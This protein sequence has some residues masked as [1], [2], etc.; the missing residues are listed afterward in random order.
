MPRPC[1]IYHHSLG[2]L[3]D[4]MRRQQVKMERLPGRLQAYEST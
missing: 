4:G 2:R 1:R 3:E